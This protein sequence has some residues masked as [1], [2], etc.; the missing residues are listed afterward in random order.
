M[1]LISIIGSNELEN[2]LE[3]QILD[4]VATPDLNIIINSESM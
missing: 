2:E 1:V 4:Q 3:F